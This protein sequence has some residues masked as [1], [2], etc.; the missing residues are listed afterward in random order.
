MDSTSFREAILADYIVKV[1]TMTAEE[2]VQ[3]LIDLKH[4]ALESSSDE[5]LIN[6]IYATREPE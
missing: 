3:E 5:E 4:R 2:L 6:Q 1:K